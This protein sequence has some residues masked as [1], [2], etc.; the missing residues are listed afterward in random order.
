MKKLFL[1]FLTVIAAAGC[2]RRETS[3]TKEDALEY[4]ESKYGIEA[5][6][7]TSHLLGNAD[8]YDYKWMG[9]EFIMN[10]GS[11]VIYDEASGQYSDDRQTEEIERDCAEFASGLIRDTISGNLTEPEI[12]SVGTVVYFDTYEGK[13]FS[14]SEYYDGS[15]ENFLKLVKPK[16][17][18]TSPVKADDISANILFDEDEDRI[19]EF[20]RGLQ[21]YF[22][23]DHLTFV[24]TDTD[25]FNEH[26]IS[27]MSRFDEGFRYYLHVSDED[28]TDVIKKRQYQFAEIQPGIFISAD[29]DDIV[30][31]ADTVSFSPAGEGYLQCSF[32]P[33]LG[34]ESINTVIR[35]EEP[36]T[37]YV[38]EDIDVYT[39]VNSLSLQEDVVLR[40]GDILYYS[41]T[42]AD[43]PDI[44]IEDVSTEGMT[45]SLRSVHTSEFDDA[46]LSVMGYKR[47]D[48]QWETVAFDTERTGSEYVWRV[49]FDEDTR[50]NNEFHF[51]F[52]YTEEGEKDVNARF[53]FDRKISTETGEVKDA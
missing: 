28:G 52:R 12:E 9:M 13:P 25:Y 5:E 8:L 1:C 6:V 53:S 47:K 33:S 20:I 34:K 24:C 29:E 30:L 19:R 2:G 43:L 39:P 23:L 31:G 36:G 45:V 48:G 37:L 42:G 16:L 3:A 46:E 35:S 7:K 11:S 18:M 49:L 10:D 26:Q 38:Y 41:E 27:S 22:Q 4:Y 44:V 21:P 14:F 15:P 32:S 50:T 17:N 51:Y 40:D